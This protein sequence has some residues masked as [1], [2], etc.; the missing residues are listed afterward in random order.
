MKGSCS[1]S[2]PVKLKMVRGCLARSFTLGTVRRGVSL[3]HSA[4]R[5]LYSFWVLHESLWGEVFSQDLKVLCGASYVRKGICLASHTCTSSHGQLEWL[6]HVLQ[7]CSL[8]PTITWRMCV[9]LAVRVHQVQPRLLIITPIYSDV[10]SEPLAVC[11]E[12]T[13]KKMTS[14]IQDRCLE[15]CF[16]NLS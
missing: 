7:W 8:L 15:C 1:N 10:S 12:V 13:N 16:S 11:Y 3:P 6:L 4:T 9:F 5:I 14:L 2:S